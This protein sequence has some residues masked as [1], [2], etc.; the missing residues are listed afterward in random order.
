MSSDTVFLPVNFIQLP[1]ILLLEERI[2]VDVVKNLR[3]IK[4]FANLQCF[5]NAIDHRTN[6]PVHDNN[7][8]NYIKQIANKYEK[9]RNNPNIAIKV[10]SFQARYQGERY[11]YPNSESYGL[12][13]LVNEIRGILVPDGT[14]DLD[15]VNCYPTIVNQLFEKY[16]IECPNLNFYV[17]NRDECMKTHNFN[18]TELLKLINYKQFNT[19]NTFLKDIHIDIYQKLIPRLKESYTDYFIHCKDNVSS[20]NRHNI[21][22]SFMA[23][24]L[25]RCEQ[26]IMHFVMQY[27]NTKGIRFGCLVYDGLHLYDD[28]I[29]DFDDLSNY[30]FENT[31]FKMKFKAKPFETEEIERAIEQ[32]NEINLTE[33]E[34][35]KERFENRHFLLTGQKS[36]IVKMNYMNEPVIFDNSKEFLKDCEINNEYMND[37]EFI[38][39]WLYIDNNK[40]WYTHFD[41]LP[42]PMMCPDH[43]YNTWTPFEFD[44]YTYQLTEE[45]QQE[46]WSI[47]DD[48][49]LH[50]ADQNE[51]MKNYLQNWLAY[52]IQSPG[53]QKNGICLLLFSSQG[54]G[55]GTFN[56][57]LSRLFGKYYTSTSKIDDVLGL[58][59]NL[60]SCK[61][62]VNIDEGVSKQMYENNEKLKNLITEPTV[63]IRKM[64]TDPYEESSYCS[65]TINSNNGGFPIEQTDRRSL[66][67]SSSKLLE[68]DLAVKINE[69][70]END[71]KMC[72]IFKRLQN[73][74]I[75]YNNPK[76][77]SDNRVKTQE[78]EEL[79]QMNLPLH[80]QW[81]NHFIDEELSFR[82]PDDTEYVEPELEYRTQHLY[83]MFDNYAKTNEAKYKITY[84]KFSKLI[85][86][87]FGQSID[88]RR[89]D[90][91]FKYRVFKISE[92]EDYLNKNQLRITIG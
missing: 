54:T 17:T 40:K 57:I 21:E 32:N 23:R 84:T 15:I 68:H 50:L 13:Y 28:P 56:K 16:K 9:S 79:R 86:P 81:L 73:L 26:F 22:G 27:F 45:E 5:Q 80:I 92:I 69:I 64:R 90:R 3:K 60:I 25:Q 47:F 6:K 42:P 82:N 29:I 77:W 4:T 72:Y 88:L 55:K 71:D 43:V 39:H 53:G 48:Y 41:F 51:H 1:M 12:L 58:Y 31:T 24:F 49:I 34:V 35:F 44:D 67:V 59:N 66:V 46:T 8:I 10:K 65:I 7:M 63:T 74:Q 2:K 83:E 37:L 76:Q 18:K 52:K 87:I 20:D 75:P 85:N 30:I 78:Y 33:Y 62:I 91:V 89:D 61:L 19:Q 70:I 11:Y 36:K 14:K 38:K